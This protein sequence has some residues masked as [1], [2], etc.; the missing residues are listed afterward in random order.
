MISPADVR[1]YSANPMAFFGDVYL[2]PGV[3]F[4]RAGRRS[5]SSS[6]KPSGPAY[7]PWH[8]ANGRQCVVALD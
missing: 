7:S 5:K 6:W 2:R 3:R 4:D 1:R 8:V